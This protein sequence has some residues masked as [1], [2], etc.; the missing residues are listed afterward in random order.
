[1]ISLVRYLWKSCAKVVWCCLVASFQLQIVTVAVAATV[2]S[3][4]SFVVCYLALVMRL[5]CASSVVLLSCLPSLGFDKK[6]ISICYQGFFI[7]GL[8][9]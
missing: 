3:C 7:I 6:K 2:T 1:V 5:S 4:A 9:L 8:L